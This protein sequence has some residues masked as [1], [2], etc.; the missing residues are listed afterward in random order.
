MNK[1]STD[2]KKIK[3][4]L[5]RGV[6]EVI[7]EKD[8]IKALKSGKRLRVKFGIDPTSP[9]IHLGHTVALKKLREFQNLGH[10]TI[11]LIGDFTA[12][13]GD[14]SGKNE[15]RKKLSFKEVQKNM[16]NYL[17]QASKVIDLKKAEIR[18]NSEWFNKWSILDF[19]E[20][21]SKITVQRALERDDFKKRLSSD[22]DVSLLEIIYPLLQGYDS[23]ALKSDVE[24]GGTDQ[25][26]NL[27]MGRKIQ[28]RYNMSEQNILTTWLIEGLDGVNKM[29]KSLNNY[30]GVTDKPNDMFGKIMS[31]PDSLIVK[32]FRVL[33][34]LSDKDID[35]IKKSIQIEKENPMKFKKQLAEKIVSIYYD[36]KE[37]SEAQKEWENVFSKKENPNEIKEIK[38][39]KK[40]RDLVWL[41]VKINNTSKSEARRL[42]EQGGVKI[43]NEKADIN[44]QLAGGEIVK[45][46]KKIFVKIK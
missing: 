20:L 26:F 3:E 21:T 17:T 30:I 23:V 10:K 42:I 28:K 33:T 8:L 44:K 46:G 38:L 18:Y 36:K 7:I 13:I 1:V 25:K 37:A 5:T 16:E 32:Y 43:N 29:S 2:A 34:D 14:P 24:I 22:Q 35:K 9:D 11:L 12:T 15:M 40:T 31:T 6:E 39:D 41:I 4:L 19:H 45:I 27:L